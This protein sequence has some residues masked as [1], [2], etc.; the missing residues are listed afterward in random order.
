MALTGIHKI[1][2][3]GEWSFVSYYDLSEKTMFPSLIYA[4][5]TFL[6]FLY[7]ILAHYVD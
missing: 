7:T 1:I 6:C 3:R 5:A 2:P 4:F